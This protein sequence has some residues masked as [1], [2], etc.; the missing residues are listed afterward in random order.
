MIK[1]NSQYPTKVKFVKH[2][3]T[4]NG[5]DVTRFSIGDKIKDSD[6][7]MNYTV[8]VFDNVNLTDGDTVIFT[9]I[10]SISA[11]VYNEKTYYEF[12]AKVQTS[13]PERASE[14]ETVPWDI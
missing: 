2:D 8:T 10:D 12:V 7:Y 4:R 6:Q 9:S 14:P 11:R 3:T 1:L 13:N 5:S